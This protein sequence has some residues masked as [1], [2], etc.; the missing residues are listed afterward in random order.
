MR[1]SLLPLAALLLV[2][3]PANAVR[4]GRPAPKPPVEDIWVPAA[5]PK[6]GV[7]WK[8]LES[9]K[10]IDRKDPKTLIIYSK[11]GFPAAVKAL[12]GK[13][14][15]ISGYMTPLQNSAKQTHFVLLGYPPGCPFHMHAMPNQFVEVKSAVPFKVQTDNPTIVS[16]TLQLMGT[17]E[18]G[19]FY[20][21]VNARPG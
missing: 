6:G 2:A 15:K 13:T 5:T 14:I 19:I 12:G 17:D 16:G 1:N 3:S 11:P 10:V 18:S 8:T 7:S 21:L 4:E 20:R 9:T